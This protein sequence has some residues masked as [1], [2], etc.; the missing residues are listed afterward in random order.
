MTCKRTT[1]RKKDAGKTK[2]IIKKIFGGLNCGNYDTQKNRRKCNDVIRKNFD[3]SQKRIQCDINNIE[4]NDISIVLRNMIG[5]GVY[6]KTY[7]SEINYKNESYDIILK[8]Q[9]VKD[10]SRE[11]IIQKELLLIQYLSLLVQKNVSPHFLHYYNELTCEY[12]E[13]QHVLKQTLQTLEQTQQTLEHTQQRLQTLEQT[14]QTQRTGQTLK[15]MKKTKQ[16]QQTLQ[17][18]EKT[19]QI[20]EQTGQT[21]QQTGQILEQTGKK[22]QQAGQEIQQTG[23]TGQTGQTQ[24]QTAQTQQL[25]RK[26]NS[27][28]KYIKTFIVE[29]ASGAFSELKETFEDDFNSIISQIILSIYTFHQY[30]KCYHCDTHYNN[31]L[32]HELQHDK[33]TYI[34]YKLDNDIYKLKLSKYL[35]ILWDYG[36][37]KSMKNADILKYTENAHM[38]DDYYKIFNMINNEN[39][40]DI[41]DDDNIDK[42]DKILDILEEY[43]EKLYNFA[44]KN[45]NHDLNVQY[46]LKLEKEMIYTFI[47]E[48]ILFADDIFSKDYESYNATPYELENIG[49]YYMPINF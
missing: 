24:Q 13:A 36:L 19:G 2:R 42:I 39:Y 49:N 12:D 28:H 37:A 43:D 17:Q 14:H 22:L 45:L 6:G 25:T 32:Y 47:K 3:V 9:I 41:H 27:F 11:V 34:K 8:Q 26:E 16:V 48:R 10:N 1:I 38:I 29:K 40:Y 44:V 18:T 5:K 33:N 20:L 4:F 21:L 7:L 30:T 46:M 23:Q 31:F 15:Q 35:I